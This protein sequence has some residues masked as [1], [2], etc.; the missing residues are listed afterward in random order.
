M[1]S[2]KQYKTKVVVNRNPNGTIRADFSNGN[3]VILDG[4][5]LRQYTRSENELSNPR[6]IDSGSK[7]NA[8]IFFNGLV[9]KAVIDFTKSN[10]KLPL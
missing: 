7:A 5:I 2:N 6:S 3:T 4:H 1:K 8:K 10:V 9:N